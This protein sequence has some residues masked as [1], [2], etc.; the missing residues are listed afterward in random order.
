MKPRL[1]G[2]GIIATLTAVALFIGCYS[3]NA[4]RDG[5]SED[6]IDKQNDRRYNQQIYQRERQGGSGATGGK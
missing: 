4:P 1:I 3:D 2:L 6:G 5:A